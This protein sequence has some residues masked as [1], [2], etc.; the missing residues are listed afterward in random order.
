MG[1]GMSVKELAALSVTEVAD[2][3]SNSSLSGY[4]QAFI[5][6]GIDGDMLTRLPVDQLV[7]ALGRA[8]VDDEQHLEFLLTEI[9][10]VRGSSSVALTHEDVIRHF[11]ADALLKENSGY[12]SSNSVVG[13]SP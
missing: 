3:I 5:D 6:F 2:L 13:T 11:K 7:D 9:E 1:S 10:N 4:R 12:H 8:G